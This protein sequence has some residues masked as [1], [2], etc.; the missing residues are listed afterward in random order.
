MHEWL[1]MRYGVFD[2][3]PLKRRVDLGSETKSDPTSIDQQNFYHSS[4][5]TY[6]AVR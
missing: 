5:S 4:H 3:H 1:H 6:E 2:E